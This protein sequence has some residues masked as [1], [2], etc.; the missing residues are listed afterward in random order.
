MQQS[1]T[2]LT[3][4][5]FL[6]F[7][8]LVTMG[9]SLYSSRIIL[10][11]LGVSDYGTYNVVGGMVAMIAFL[12]YSLNGA[13][14]RF[15]NFAIAKG[16]ISEMKLVFNTAFYIHAIIALIIIVLGETI[17]LWFF[18][19][20]LN[21]PEHRMHA[22][23]L[24]YQ[25]S[26]ATM[27]L[28]VM[29]IP[30]DSAII[31]HQKMK[32]FAYISILESFLKLAVAYAVLYTLHDKLM[33]Y[34]FLLLCTSLIIRLI[35]QAYCRRKFSECRLSFLFDKSIFKEIAVFFSWDLFGNISALLRTQGVNV[36]Q[37]IF[38][39][40]IVNAAMGIATIVGSAVTSISTNINLALK[41]QIFQAF[42]LGNDQK[43]LRII[44]V[45]TKASFFILTIIC[46]PLLLNTKYF[47]DF[48]LGNAP[49]FSV[50]FTQLV[51]I[52]CL[53]GGLFDY[54]TVLI[55]ATGKIKSLS[56]LGGFTYIFSVVISY[57]LLKYDFD[58]YTTSIIAIIVNIFMGIGILYITKLL[59]QNFPVKE[60]LLNVFVKSIFVFGL[61][62]GI[63]FYMNN[64]I[65]TH[66]NLYVLS[67]N[68]GFILL[69][70]F[71]FGM[72]NNE[73]RELMKIVR[74]FLIRQK[75]T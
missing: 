31:A 54:L 7:R 55:N 46:I 29:Q 4:I 11:A 71:V 51:L 36:L 14:M 58:M 20:K 44:E 61:A 18:Y 19:N 24:V 57:I 27:V 56:L 49:Q 22:A 38:F 40:T 9:I 42:S 35:Y 59:K 62:F 39:G 52:S 53:I 5:V 3:N 8:M 6:L 30:Y 26:I 25:F 10:E 70:I 28:N 64:Y 63:C 13:T 45:G 75:T 60:F 47:L 34:G 65:L 50:N 21:I 72:K 15:M 37:N 67:A 32:I 68:I 74:N 69:V 73:K 41:P 1:K 48:W 66:F 23:A 2:A 12:H 16:E 43:L 17:G 33:V